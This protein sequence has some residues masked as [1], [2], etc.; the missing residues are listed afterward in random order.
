MTWKDID[1][2]R[3][4]KKDRAYAVGFWRFLEKDPSKN[5]RVGLR[6]IPPELIQSALKKERVRQ[7]RFKNDITADVIYN[8]TRYRFTQNNSNSRRLW[9]EKIE[10]FPCL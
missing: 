3:I 6:D 10:E 2:N 9:V 1:P 5:A 7:G 4:R 8:D